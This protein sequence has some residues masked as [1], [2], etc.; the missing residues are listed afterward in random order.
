[1]RSLFS[2]ARLQLHAIMPEDAHPGV[3]GELAV[4][5]S[6]RTARLLHIYSQ[7]SACCCARLKVRLALGQDKSSLRGPQHT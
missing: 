2:L 5:G 1:M 4:Q 6:Y 7:A 3:K